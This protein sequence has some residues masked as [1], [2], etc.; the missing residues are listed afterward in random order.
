MNATEEIS[1]K[2]PFF[3]ES[4]KLTV[5]CESFIGNT[6]MLTKFR[7]LTD[8]RHHIR[9]CCSQEDGGECPLAMN[10]Y[11]KYERAEA[12]REKREKE[13]KLLDLK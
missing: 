12:L 11:D 2:C 6:V 5:S 7:T 3:C 4:E 13:R 10:L 9:D 1:I 8:F